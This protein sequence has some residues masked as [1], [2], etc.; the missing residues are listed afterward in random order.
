MGPC[1]PCRPRRGRTSNPNPHAYPN[2]NPNPNPNSDP[3]PEQAWEELARACGG[4]RC[5]LDGVELLLRR[6]VE[7][8]EDKTAELVEERAKLVELHPAAQPS[9]S[10]H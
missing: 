1:A 8:V 10:H 4:P 5:L 9:L 3:D 7:L 2:P 6:G